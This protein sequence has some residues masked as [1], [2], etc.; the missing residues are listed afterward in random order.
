MI[1]AMPGMHSQLHAVMN[2][3]GDYEGLSSNYSGAGFS[4]MRFR[5]HGMVPR[6]FV[7]WVGEARASGQTLDR[8]E[9]LALAQPSIAAPAARYASVETGLFDRV[10]NRCV[11]EGRM[12]AN[13]MAR[14]DALGGTGL[15]G[16]INL[17]PSGGATT[18]FG[19]T[20]FYV[21]DLCAPMPATAAAGTSL[22]LLS[23][24]APAPSGE[25]D[26]TF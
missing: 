25:A 3:P 4:N 18:P 13:E 16:T 8:A 11:E 15:A 9:Y 1:Y 26:E 2:Y 6:D 5:F 17:L 14:L 21:A 22:A 24:Q 20:P 12:C 23:P 10:V 7:T 19:G